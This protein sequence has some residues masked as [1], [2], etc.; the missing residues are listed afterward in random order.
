MSRARN[1]FEALRR[2]ACKHSGRDLGPRRYAFP[3]SLRSSQGRFTPHSLLRSRTSQ[4]I[5]VQS[6]ATVL[7]A[8][9]LAF[10][11]MRLTLLRFTVQPA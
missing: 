11:D 4:D 1:F 2:L 3:A 7:L 6:L 8:H 5:Q 9:A 10:A